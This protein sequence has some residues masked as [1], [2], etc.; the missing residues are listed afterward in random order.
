MTS[1]I[2]IVLQV[3]WVTLNNMTQCIYCD[4]KTDKPHFASACCGRGMCDEC[5]NSD[6]GT[7]EQVQVSYMDAYDFDKNI[8]GTPYERAEY[9]CFEHLET[10]KK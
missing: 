7:S 5:Y 3:L 10:L 8:K 2:S 6:V 4:N 1:D 9:I